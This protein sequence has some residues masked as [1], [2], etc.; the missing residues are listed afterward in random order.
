MA[1]LRVLCAPSARPF[2]HHERVPTRPRPGESAA[3][4]PVSPS[5]ETFLICAG[6]GEVTSVKRL[7]FRNANS[8]DVKTKFFGIG[9]GHVQIEVS[10]YFVRKYL[11]MM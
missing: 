7:T 5:L 10:K 11:A 1:S 2:A 8:G 6:S 9:G 3:P 4:A